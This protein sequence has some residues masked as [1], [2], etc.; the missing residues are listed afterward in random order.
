MSDQPNAELEQQLRDLTA[1]EGPTPGLWRRAMQ[2][3]NA[4]RRQGGALH[5]L[6]HTVLRRVPSW[7]L[8]GA[9]AA[10]VFMA[11]GVMMTGPFGPTLSADLSGEAPSSRRG[12][13]D[14][15]AKG[16]PADS[17]G[18]YDFTT[19]AGEL[20]HSFR[21]DQLMAGRAAFGT[22]MERYGNFDGDGVPAR[23]TVLAG[24]AERQVARSVTMEL[25]SPDVRA[26]FLK[27][28]Q[29]ISPA[30]GEYVQESSLS[31][32]KENLQ[33]NLTL[34]V[35]AERLSDVLNEL[36]TLG[37]VQA[38]VA[39][40][41]DVTDQAVDLE[42]RL[43]N[44][45]RVEQELLE[46][47]QR[48]EDAPLKDVLALR[49]SLSEVRETIER[50]TAQREHLAHLVSLATVLVIVR[51]TDAVTPETPDGLAAYF[52]EAL[53]SAWDAGTKLLAG[54]LAFVLQTLVGGAFWWVLLIVAI[55]AFR[56][57]RRQAAS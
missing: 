27:A 55:L 57:W 52:A 11:V 35:S 31:G 17:A 28:Q 42:A 33:A 43:R 50:I 30:R 14:V 8:T 24:V 37:D 45:Q 47:L 46:L 48:R 25:R 7:A 15:G 49:Q 51:P 26:V 56:R 12:R 19:E 2:T 32:D 29:L 39:R 44:E 22:R 4:G 18:L 10:I 41:D 1:W 6:R 23:G 34:R 5:R 13:G 40:G 54:S 38:E 3:A 53:A 16:L 21:T 20:T 9:A 36:R